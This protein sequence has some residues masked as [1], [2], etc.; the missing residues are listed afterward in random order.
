MASLLVEGAE[1]DETVAHDVRIGRQSCTYLIH[2][3]LRHLVPILMMTVDDLQPAAI[4][5]TDGSSHLQVL[6]RRAVPLLFFLWTNLDIET[7]GLQ[8]LANQ[9]VE[10][11]AGI[12]AA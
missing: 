6:F 11:Y 4:L 9:F 2:R 8:T 10:H 3:V 5:V 1:L 12:D 7:V